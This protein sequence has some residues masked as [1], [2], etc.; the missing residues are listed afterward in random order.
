M[1]DPTGLVA[2]ASSASTL[3]AP[4]GT[5]PQSHSAFGIRRSDR[6]GPPSDDSVARCRGG[7]DD[8]GCEQHDAQ[9]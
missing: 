6:H 3:A 9:G 8:D 7:E 1:A 2:I 4:A 5:A